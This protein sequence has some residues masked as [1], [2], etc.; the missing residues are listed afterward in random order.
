MNVN[1]LS[2]SPSR[3]RSTF[4]FMSEYPIVVLTIFLRSLK[5]AHLEYLISLGLKAF[6]QPRKCLHEFWWGTISNGIT[7]YLPRYARDRKHHLPISIHYFSSQHHAANHFTAR[8]NSCDDNKRASRLAA[9]FL[10]PVGGLLRKIKRNWLS[11]P[12]T[13]RCSNS[14]LFNTHT[15]PRPRPT[16]TLK[17]GAEIFAFQLQHYSRAT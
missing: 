13:S 5:T 1:C 3:G 7:L 2:F 15:F 10:A 11:V 12:P 4:P 8:S 14:L 16:S 9:K 17:L 6:K